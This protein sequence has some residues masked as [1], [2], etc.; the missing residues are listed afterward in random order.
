LRV[1]ANANQKATTATPTNRL[2]LL[3]TL[4]G[5]WSR[6]KGRTNSMAAVSGK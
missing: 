1:K 2:K 5:H 3:A 4:L 6:N